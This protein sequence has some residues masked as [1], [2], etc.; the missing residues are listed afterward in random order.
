MNVITRIERLLPVLITSLWM[1][2]T[3]KRMTT[4]K[5]RSGGRNKRLANKLT[6]DWIEYLVLS[7]HL[8]KDHN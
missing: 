4:T 5:I 7:I 1:S 8:G 6:F 2:Q 3:T